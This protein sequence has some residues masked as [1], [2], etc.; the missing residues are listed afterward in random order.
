MESSVD[1][2]RFA[3]VVD[4][5]C[6]VMALVDRF[7]KKYV[8]LCPIQCVLNSQVAHDDC[9]RKFGNWTCWEFFLSSWVELSCVGGVYVPVGCRDPV[10][11]SAAYMWLAQKI[12][13]WVTTD[14]CC[15]H[16]AD[17]TQLDFVVGKLFRLVET[18]RDCRQ[19]VANSIHTAVATQL[20]S[21]VASASAVCIGLYCVML[22]YVNLPLILHN[23][24]W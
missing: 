16:T 24:D 10:Y 5:V 4:N 23:F 22:C 6:H 18:R 13:N 8:M 3:S 1:R 21:W 2:H 9:R 14:D 20:D 17:T 15:V 19:L 11:N 7:N 12:G